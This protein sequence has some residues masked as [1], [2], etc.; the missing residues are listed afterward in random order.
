M[1]SCHERG[2]DSWAGLRGNIRADVLRDLRIRFRRDDGPAVDNFR[3]RASSFLAPGVL[4]IFLHRVAHYFT[5]RG[6]R[7]SGAIVSRI[8]ALLH[9]INI[10]PQ[11]CIGPGAFIPHPVGVTFH[12]TA[13]A[14]LTLFSLAACC[15]FENEMHGPAATGPTIGDRVIVGRAMIL[16]PVSI[17]DESH[18]F[19]ARVAR[20]IPPRSI[21]ISRIARTR[22]VLRTPAK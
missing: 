22:A 11:S 13:G 18:I 10:T 17:G 7:R 20:D 14:Q 21:V 8:N 4:A 3:H 9:K 1:S 12:G 2:H 19:A 6:W 16:G 15:A 5:V